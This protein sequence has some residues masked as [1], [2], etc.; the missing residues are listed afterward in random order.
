MWLALIK[1]YWQVSLL[2]RTPADTVYSPLLLGLSACFYFLLI[3]CQWLMS[4]V[5]LNFQ[6]TKALT[7]ATALTG[8]YL[9]YTFFLLRL[10]HV[11]NRTVQTL[12]SLFMVHVLIHLF[13]V[14]LLV[15]NPLLLKTN[16]E[17]M[18]APFLGVLYLFMTFIL[19]LWQLLSVTFIYKH[20]LS[21]EY[22]NGFL[23][24]LGLLACNVLSVSMV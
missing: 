7:I 11:A 22:L 6:I 18:L 5:E 10:F 20:A 21:K 9:V 4:D 15:L 16:T 19:T 8:S 14:P 12:T 1:Q 24:S 2:K 17:Q 13:A 3:A 23:A